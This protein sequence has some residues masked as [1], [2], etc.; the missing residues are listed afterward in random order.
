MSHSGVLG[1]RAPMYEFGG[2]TA[3]LFSLRIEITVG[4]Y[5][6]LCFPAAALG[7][8][9]VASSFLAWATGSPELTRRQSRG[10]LEKQNT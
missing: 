2:D 10:L 1:I 6:Q 9:A 8:P 5:P 7:A 4:A 3:E